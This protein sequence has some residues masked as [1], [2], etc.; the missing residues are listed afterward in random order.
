MKQLL[1]G[2]AVGLVAGGVGTYAVLTRATE[3]EFGELQRGNELLAEAL[4]ERDSAAAE[5]RAAIAERDRSI[6]ALEARGPE[7]RTRA[8]V[9]RAARVTTMRE[10]REYLVGDSTGLALL[11]R[12]EMASRE[13]IL[14]LEARIEVDSLLL[15]DWIGQTLDYRR[16]YLQADSSRREL[17]IQSG[18][19]QAAAEKWHLKARPPFA[20]RLLESCLDCGLGGLAAGIAADDPAVGVAAGAVCAGVKE[21]R[22]RLPLPLPR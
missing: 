12:R 22:V 19:W 15:I 20:V 18:L 11:D 6:T 4:L 5:L 3:E 13:H 1:T 7:I 10:L 21:L 17:E 16:L 8:A 9:S 14:A 2:L